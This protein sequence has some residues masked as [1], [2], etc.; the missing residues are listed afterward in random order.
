MPVLFAGQDDTKHRH[1]LHN[2]GP[3]SMYARNVWKFVSKVSRRGLS[4][5]RKRPPQS[6]DRGGRHFWEISVS[7]PDLM[8]GMGVL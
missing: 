5:P 4:L 1:C 3:G 8:T 2:W 6:M 7:L